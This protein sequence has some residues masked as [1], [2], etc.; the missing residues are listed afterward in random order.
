MPWHVVVLQLSAAVLIF[1]AR[2]GEQVAWASRSTILTP[3]LKDLRNHKQQHLGWL[4]RFG[5][6]EVSRRGLQ[7]GVATPATLVFH[8]IGDLLQCARG[9][10]W[11][12]EQHG[13]ACLPGPSQTKPRAD[14]QKQNPANFTA[15]TAGCIAA[16]PRGREPGKRQHPHV[17][18]SVLAVISGAPQMSIVQ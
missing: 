15:P 9:K 3:P 14:K 10:G 1:R 4:T 5:H 16:P 13:G 7:G 2:L 12:G 17:C 6:R 11:C 18:A 8:C